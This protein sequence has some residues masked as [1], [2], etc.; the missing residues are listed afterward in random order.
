M[1]AYGSK[2]EEVCLG[3]ELE[4]VEKELR[5]LKSSATRGAGNCAA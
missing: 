3:G 4:D 1:G 2:A 5:D